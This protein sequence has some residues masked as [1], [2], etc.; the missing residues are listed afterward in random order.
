MDDL[1]FSPTTVVAVANETRT[2]PEG[3]PFNGVIGRT[4]DDSVPAWP[5]GPRAA[6]GAPN[7]VYVLLDD[8]GY[9][10]LGC[11]GGHSRTPVID[12]I[13]DR[14]LRYRN[15]HTTAMCSP[16]RAAL[17]TGRNSHTVGMGGITD[18][19][20]GYPGYNARLTK[21]SAFISEVLVN[22]GWSTWA[23]GKWHLAPNEEMDAAAPRKR[24]P[25]GRGFE[26]YYGFIGA[27]TNQWEPDLVIDNHHVETPRREGYHLTEDLV[28]QAID[29]LHDHRNVAPTKPFFTYL[30]FGA[31]HAP[32]HVPTE[33]IDRE[34]GRWDLGW[35]DERA[36]THERQLASGIL[37]SGTDLSPRPAWIP[38][39]SSLDADTRRV[40][41]HQMEVFAAFLAHTDYH[42]GR[43]VDALAATGDLDNTIIVL[44]SDNGAS[45]EGSLN[46]SFNENLFFNLELDTVDNQLERYDEHGGPKSYPHY[47]FGWAHAGNSPFQRWKRET[48]EGGLADPLLI[49]WPAGLAAR[50]EIRTQYT[51]AIDITPTVLDLVGVALPETVDG[52]R[53]K[54]LDGATFASSLARLDAPEHRVTQFYEQFACRAIYH[55]GWKAVCYHS[56]GATANYGAGDPSRSLDDDPW[57]L[58]QVADD[59]SESH[60]L[61]AADPD[62]LARMKD[63]WWAEAGRF[64]ALPLQTGR[65]IKMPRPS[66]HAST[67]ERYIYRRGPAPIPMQHAPD[68]MHRPHVIEADITVPAEGADG[69]LV[70]HGG[71][72]GGYALYILEGHAHWI[73]NR[74]GVE[75]FVL[76]SPD[77]VGP[78]RHFVGVQFTPDGMAK[79]DVTLLVDGEEVASMHVPRMVLYTYSLVGDDFC[80]GHDSASAV[81][82]YDAPFSYAGAIHHVAVDVSGI[83]HRDLE[84][85]LERSWRTQ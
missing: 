24:W 3:Q 85:E 27:E 12:A 54:P 74:L 55:D 57:E 13:A 23:I 56:M 36:A 47:S 43:Y 25:L 68:V 16:T 14:G 78:G 82:P 64:Q 32:H 50:G 22:A 1:Y 48:H 42:L 58:Y 6:A 18:Q 52:F 4:K 2:Y 44:I 15:F 70:A 45:A 17:L 66:A 8:V 65:A 11:F 20:T 26:R 67:R 38:A 60:D 41:A 28:D 5:V 53:Q 72:F 37:P 35:D 34:K 71:R 61:A 21:D 75:S 62:R 46:G 19:A 80:I 51:H 77:P 76:R 63:L 83:T 30:A 81:G 49:S 40:Y 84:R 7:V 73:H 59:A 31:A 10:Q 69:V 9:A 39:W 79:G 33:W 29:L